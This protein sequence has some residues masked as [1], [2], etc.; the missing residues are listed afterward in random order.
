MNII[1]ICTFVRCRLIALV[2]PVICLLTVN[3]ILF[4]CL[5]L[6]CDRVCMNGAVDPFWPACHCSFSVLF[7][8]KIAYVNIPHP[9]YNMTARN[10]GILLIHFCSPKPTEPGLITSNWKS[11]GE[12]NRKLQNNSDFDMSQCLSVC[13]RLTRQSFASAPTPHIRLSIAC[14]NANPYD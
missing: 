2:P 8:R 3:P 12:Q 10:L 5:F 4:S 6:L 9:Q 1:C 13:V 11:G 14:N 7:E